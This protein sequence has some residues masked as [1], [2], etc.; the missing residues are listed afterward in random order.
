MTTMKKITLGALLAASLMFATTGVVNAAVFKSADEKF[1]M[2]TPDDS[3]EEKA[4][5]DNDMTLTNGKDIVMVKKFD[6]EFVNQDPEKNLPSPTVA[7]DEYEEEFLAYYSTDKDVYM[8]TGLAQKEED[9]NDVRAI[10][11]SIKLADHTYPDAKK[12]EKEK[13]DDDKKAKK[14]GNEKTV[15]FENSNSITIYEYTNGKW[16]GDDGLEYTAQT[17]NS[18]VNSDGVF[19]YNYVPEVTTAKKTGNS[20]QIYYE[21]SNSV[22]IYE[23]DDGTYMDDEHI[24]YTNN[25]DGTWTSSQG[26]TLYDDPNGGMNKDK[27]NDDDQQQDDDN[28]NEDDGNSSEDNE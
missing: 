6:A 21:N 1:T 10:V 3:W 7:H 24:K 23:Y 26:S 20:L 18:W 22:T 14:T 19:V 15:Y 8:I 5:E 25:G 9:I 2:E 28:G 11:N 16:I 4:D 12:K 17:E 27:D 13:D